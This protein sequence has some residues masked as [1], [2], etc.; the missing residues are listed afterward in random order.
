M[1]AEKS[2]ELLRGLS[3]CVIDLETT[4]GNHESDQIIEIGMVRVKNL[5][6]ADEKNFLID[7]EMSIPD[8]IQRL[9]SIKQKDVKGCPKIEDVIDEVLDF[10]GDD[11]IVAHNISFDL[12]FLNSVLRR[13]GKTELPNRNICTNV[14]TKHMIPEI[15]SSNLN[16]M[17]QLFNIDHSK[18]HRAHD[19]AMATAKLLL[20]YLDIFIEKG[21]QK[22][23]QLYYPRNKFELDRIHFSQ[24][25]DREK[26][27]AAVERNN[28]SML[29]TLKGDRGLILG[30]LPLE[31]P[32]EQMD[33][34][35]KF[36]NLEG[37]KRLTIRLVKPALEGL[38]QFNNHLLKYPEEN[39]V[40]LLDYLN[41]RYE[42]PSKKA[43]AFNIEELDFVLAHHLVK[44]QIIVYSFLNLNTNSKAI[45]KF[46]GQRKKLLN[47]LMAQVKRFEQ[48]QKGKRKVLL[49]K[50]ARPLIESFL[51][52]TKSQNKYLY[53]S[54]KQIKESESS[55]LKLVD[56]FNREDV[57]DYEFPTNH[58]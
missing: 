1:S 8:F 44:D 19:D 35:E 54:R 6:I 9:T 26:I 41:S 21:I 13:L 25:A 56:S 15:M 4:G 22:I 52:K 42:V 16:Y 30:A 17:S 36:I 28:S 49:N 29:I 53:L 24:K 51:A 10:I 47:F 23:N 27:L 43:S 40:F 48:N 2:I 7:P 33:V 50:E 12:P 32:S 31:N 39:K 57:E 11:I 3:F 14:M 45:F 46:P 34:V 55:A 58:L 38:F 18:A 5:A 37:W 20:K